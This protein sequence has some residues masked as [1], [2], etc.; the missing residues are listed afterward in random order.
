MEHRFS[1]RSSGARGCFYLD[2]GELR[3]IS[4]TIERSD[5]STPKGVILYSFP[6][7]QEASC[8]W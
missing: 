1:A 5:S 7:T 8:L 6:Y 4:S 3:L 2:S